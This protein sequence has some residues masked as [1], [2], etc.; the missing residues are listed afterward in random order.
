[1]TEFGFPLGQASLDAVHEKNVGH[2]Y[3]STLHI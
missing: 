1:V 2:G 3:I